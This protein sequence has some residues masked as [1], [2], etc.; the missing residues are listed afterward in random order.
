MERRIVTQDGSR[1]SDS[2]GTITDFFWIHFCV[3]NHFL[4]AALAIDPWVNLLC[5]H[6]TLFPSASVILCH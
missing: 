3:I 6:Q 5:C 1:I 4:D 2:V